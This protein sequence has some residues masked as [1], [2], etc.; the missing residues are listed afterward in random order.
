MKSKLLLWLAILILAIVPTAFGAIRP[1]FRLDQ[2]AWKAT[3]IVIAVTTATDGT[4]EVVES[5]RGDLHVGARLLI[6]D[7]RPLGEADSIASYLAKPESVLCHPGSH[8]I[9]KQPVGSRVILFL[10]GGTHQPSSDGKAEIEG[11][12]PSDNMDSMQASVVWIEG[13]GLYAFEQVQNP[14]LPLLCPLG[15]SE[16]DVRNRVAEIARI[17]SRPDPEQVVRRVLTQPSKGIYVTTGWD[18][19]QLRLLGDSAAG[20]VL[21][22]IEGRDVPKNEMAQILLIIQYS[23]ESPLGIKVDSDRQPKSASILVAKLQ[24][25]PA[26][27]GLKEDFHGTKKVLAAARKANAH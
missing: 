4:F 1:S 14:G 26:A 8:L 27:S 25:M 22:L 10:V 5:L 21:K 24:R 23:F 2:A 16:T 13:S 6:P 7:L 17:Q 9:P 11:W 20:E 19:K 3:H 18:Y 15:K 12:R